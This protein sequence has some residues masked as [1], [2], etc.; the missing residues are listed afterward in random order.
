MNFLEK[1]I[2]SVRKIS[3]KDHKKLKNI[4]LT[5]ITKE[6]PFGNYVAVFYNDELC[7]LK[8]YEDAN[9]NE[10]LEK[11]QESFKKAELIYKDHFEPPNQLKLY[12]KGTDFEVSVWTELLKI[13]KGKTINYN[14]IAT[15]LGNPNSVRAVGNAVGKNPIAYIV[16][17]HRVI[18]KN[19]ELGGFTA[20]PQRKLEMF[21][22]EGA[23]I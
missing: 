8:F 15:A 9:L 20:G 13:E 1:E 10:C 18:R 5:Y 21:H 17:C 23:N 6:S 12:L 4:S 19:G 3:T 16:P 22:Y 7:C 2:L 11:I 14:D